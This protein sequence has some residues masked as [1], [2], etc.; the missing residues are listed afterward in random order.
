MNA[1]S[2][3]PRGFARCRSKPQ[4]ATLHSSSAVFRISQIPK[5]PPHFP[6]LIQLFSR[7]C[8]RIIIVLL[9][10]YILHAVWETLQTTDVSQHG[11]G[12]ISRPPP[13]SFLCLHAAEYPCL[14]ANLAI[15]TDLP[16]YDY[17]MASSRGK[18][19]SHS[20]TTTLLNSA[21]TGATIAVTPGSADGP[22]STS[23]RATGC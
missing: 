15:Q 17:V 21:E 19:S 12:S 4:A 8:T 20:T 16:K 5:I 1:A 22:R 7:W 11:D 23:K 2:S 10:R 3:A 18:R 14:S 6:A 13:A 9:Y